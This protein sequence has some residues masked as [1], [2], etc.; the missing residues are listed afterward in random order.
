MTWQVLVYWWDL[1]DY[2]CVG[3]THTC[4]PMDI[5][6]DTF[7]GCWFDPMKRKR[8][9]FLHW[10][11]QHILESRNAPC[12]DI[13]NPPSNWHCKWFCLLDDLSCLLAY[14]VHHSTT[15]INFDPL[16]HWLLCFMSTKILVHHNGTKCIFFLGQ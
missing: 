16:M 8:W 6:L 7:A 2:I 10:E 14:Q 15:F 9:L 1:L 11:R 4:G 12:F 5:V 3:L 13:C